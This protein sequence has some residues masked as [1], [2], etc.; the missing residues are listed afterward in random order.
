LYA[1]SKSELLLLV[2]NSTYAEA[3]EQRQ[4]APLA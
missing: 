2:Q 1:R 4:A 3:L